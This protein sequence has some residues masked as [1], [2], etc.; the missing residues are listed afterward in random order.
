MKTTDLLMFISVVV[1]YVIL[2]L[3]TTAYTLFIE[4]L[5]NYEPITNQ[6]C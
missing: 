1:Y 6:L 3:Y 2:P 5:F 4:L